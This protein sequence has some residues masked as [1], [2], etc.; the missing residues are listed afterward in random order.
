MPSC[1]LI[2]SYG[3]NVVVKI[4]KLYLPIKEMTAPTMISINMMFI[5]SFTSLF[6]PGFEKA[7]A[8]LDLGSIDEIT[9]NFTESLNAEVEE[10]VTEALN[11]T[12]SALNTSSAILSNGSNVSSSQIIISNNQSVS[13]SAGQ[14]SLI[15]NQIINENGVCTATKIGGSGNDTLSSEGVCN[16]QLTGGLGADKFTCGQGTDTIRDYSPNEGDN[17]IDRQSCETIL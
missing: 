5:I 8:S 3:F 17:I 16:D 4:I 12:K 11:N 1:S 10:I 9:Q 13:A 14:G 2:L 15:L 7:L 6:F